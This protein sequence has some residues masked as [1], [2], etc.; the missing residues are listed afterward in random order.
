[1]ADR[2]WIVTKVTK[3]AQAINTRFDDS[4]R[5]TG[6]PSA[7]AKKA[8]TYVCGRIGKKVKGRC[9]MTITVQEIDYRDEPVYDS[10]DI[11]IL[12]KY[13]IKRCVNRDENNQKGVTVNINGKSVTFNYKTKIVESYGRV[14]LNNHLKNN[15]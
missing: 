9:T 2:Y 4:R 13:K 7:A 14:L 15:R 10:H 5:Y 1:M 6:T 11:P 12:Y 8:M 3:S